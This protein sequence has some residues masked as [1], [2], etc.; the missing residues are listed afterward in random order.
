MQ[1][2]QFKRT[3][4]DEQINEKRNIYFLSNELTRETFN[5]KNI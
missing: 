3:L 4:S 5:K 1:S 2:I